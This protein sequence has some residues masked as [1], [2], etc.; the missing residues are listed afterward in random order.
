MIGGT[1]LRKKKERY[2]EDRMSREI[3]NQR[4]GAAEYLGR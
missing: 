2:E 4:A 1:C 3:K